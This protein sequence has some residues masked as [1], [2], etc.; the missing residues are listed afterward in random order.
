MGSYDNRLLLGFAMTTFPSDEEIRLKRIAE[1]KMRETANQN[2]TS[3]IA[4]LKVENPNMSPEEEA[5]TWQ[6]LYIFH[7]KKLK[8]EYSFNERNA[9][10]A[11]PTF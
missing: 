7:L 5:D 1:Q 6:S 8:G 2:A 4:F 11:P 3:D 9:R 10:N